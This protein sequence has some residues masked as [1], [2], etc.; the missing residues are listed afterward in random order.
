MLS[1]RASNP[2]IRV[3]STMN[4]APRRPADFVNFRGAGRG[5]AERGAHPWST[6]ISYFIPH[7][8]FMAFHLL[9]SILYTSQSRWWPRVLECHSACRRQSWIW[10]TSPNIGFYICH[11]MAKNLLFPRFFLI[12][13]RS[14][15]PAFPKRMSVSS[16][17]SLS[18]P[19]CTL[20]GG[21]STQL[22]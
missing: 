12:D 13:S 21:L 2:N 22:Q 10:P 6:P 15:M 16:L 11:L 9:L 19:G 1:R 20:S 8:T 5:G 4:F 3:Y 7:L 17:T 18:A 14:G